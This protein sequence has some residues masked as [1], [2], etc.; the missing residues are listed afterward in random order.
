[1]IRYTNLETKDF[2]SVWNQCSILLRG[3]SWWITKLK[4]F[5]DTFIIATTGSIPSNGPNSLC[6]KEGSYRRAKHWSIERLFKSHRTIRASIIFK[7]TILS[8]FFIFIFVISIQLRANEIEWIAD[9][10]GWKQPLYQEY[11]ITY[12]VSKLWSQHCLKVN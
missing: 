12:T 5:K 3:S 11:K 6:L 8:L 4:R 9:L 10:W 1:M 2:F 7:R